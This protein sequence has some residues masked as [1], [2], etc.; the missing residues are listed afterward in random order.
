TRLRSLCL[1]TRIIAPDKI[2]VKGFLIFFVFFLVFFGLLTL[3]IEKE[4]NL[5]HTQYLF[6]NI[7]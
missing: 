6:E 4:L 7:V 3:N 5:S 2:L 1:W